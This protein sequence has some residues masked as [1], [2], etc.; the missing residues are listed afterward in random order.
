VQDGGQRWL[1]SPYGAVSWV[2]NVRANPQVSVRRGG[3]TELL[4]AV[5][6]D[7]ETAGPVLLTYVGAAPITAPYFDAKAGDPVQDFV[8]EASRHPVFRLIARQATA[9]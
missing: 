6:A 5:E 9:G 2:H 4:D 7:A 1:V 8:A 3:K